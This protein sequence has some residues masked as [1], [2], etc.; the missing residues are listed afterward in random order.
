MLNYGAVKLTQ[1]YR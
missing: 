1:C